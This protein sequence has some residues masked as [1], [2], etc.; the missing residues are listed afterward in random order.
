MLLALKGCIQKNDEYFFK[1]VLS[2][3][4]R[5]SYFVLINRTLAEETTVYNKE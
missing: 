4:S 5:N 3:F 2:D 1:K